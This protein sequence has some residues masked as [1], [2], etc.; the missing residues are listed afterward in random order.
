MMSAV[1]SASE[2]TPYLPRVVIRELAHEP[3]DGRARAARH[4]RLRRR[5]G[6]HAGCPSGSRAWGREGAEQLSDA[7]GTSFAALL[8]VAYAQRRRPA[9][10]RRRR[11]AAA[12]RGRRPRRARLPR[13][14]RHAPRAA[15]AG[16]ARCRRAR[17]P[18]RMSLGV[19]SGAVHLF[20]AGR[21]A[22]RAGVRRPGGRPRSLRME[23]AAGAG[24]I[25]VSPAVAE[26]CRAR[27]AR[28]AAPAPGG[29]ARAAPPGATAAPREPPVDGR[30]RRRRAGLPT[31]VRA[32]VLGGRRRARAPA[33]HASR[34]CASTAPT[35]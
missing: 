26:R 10:V 21:L 16:P 19:H 15:R 25:V 7:I 8:G 24:E 32:H 18:L 12:V 34:S 27:C 14:D 28:R 11:A 5:R 1:R 23:R 3:A 6:L 33:R 20:L 17:S 13:G 22:P 9:E 31:A 2:L 4:A 29:S 30:R 35:R